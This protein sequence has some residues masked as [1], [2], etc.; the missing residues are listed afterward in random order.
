[1]QSVA[2]REQQISEESFLR[3]HF[4]DKKGIFSVEV[5]LASGQARLRPGAI[6]NL[7]VLLTTDPMS[8][9]VSS[10]SI[11]EILVQGYARNTVHGPE[12]TVRNFESQI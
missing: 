9:A 1:M 8:C 6:K 11:K 12:I 3:K 10:S 2:K 7:R 5:L 4:K